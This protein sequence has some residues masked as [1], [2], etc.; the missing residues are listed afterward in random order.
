MF[1][2]LLRKKFQWFPLGEQEKVWYTMSKDCPMQEVV[3]LGIM[4]LL[5]E[6]NDW[7]EE[8]T[9][10][11]IPPEESETPLEEPAEAEPS[12]IVEEVIL[13]DAPVLAAVAPAPRRRRSIAVYILAAIALLS[14]LVLAMTVVV[15]LPHFE[16]TE[17]PEIV[18]GHFQEFQVTEAVP[19]TILEP[20]ISET[21]EATIPPARNPYDRYDFQYDRHN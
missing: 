11:P 21:A 16:K 2:I 7:T 12:L 5:E 17:A 6:M 10:T 1:K 14:G 15:C 18:M 9:Q 3:F 13:P 8:E 4:D 19:E 20:T